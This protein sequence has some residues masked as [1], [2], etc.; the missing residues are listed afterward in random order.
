MKKYYG[1]LIGAVLSAIFCSIRVVQLYNEFFIVKQYTVTKFL[2]VCSLLV[3]FNA[4][5]CMIIGSIGDY[6]KNKRINYF[7]CLTHCAKLNDQLLYYIPVL[8]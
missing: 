6:I 1:F 5:G 7:N 3:T 2:I 8:D 4:F